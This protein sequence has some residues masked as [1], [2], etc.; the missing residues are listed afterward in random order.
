MGEWLEHKVSRRAFCRVAVTPC[1]VPHPRVVSSHVRAEVHTVY[2]TIVGSLPRNVDSWNF[3]HYGQ[4]TD[5]VRPYTGEVTSTTP[6]PSTKGDPCIAQFL[7][8]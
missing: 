5:V 8:Q 4:P 2:C 6:F 1:R 7:M 3:F